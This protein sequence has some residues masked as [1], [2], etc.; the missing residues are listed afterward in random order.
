[1]D[2][3]EADSVGRLSLSRSGL[4][5][6]NN[7]V[8]SHAIEAGAALVV[9]MGGGYSRPVDASAQAHADVY[10]ALALRFA[11]LARAEANAAAATA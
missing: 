1:M 9:C 4:L 6:R 11:P 10:R 3:L 2:P 7:L 5:Q 8:Y